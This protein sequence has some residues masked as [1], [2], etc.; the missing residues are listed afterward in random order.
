MKTVRSM[1]PPGFLMMTGTGTVWHLTRLQRV[2][3]RWICIQWWRLWWYRKR[4]Q[5]S[6]IGILRRCRSIVM[7]QLRRCEW[8]DNLESRLWWWW[9][10]FKRDN[11]QPVY[12]ATYYVEDDSDCDDMEANSYPGNTKIAMISTMTV[13]DIRTM[14]IV[15]ISR[16][17]NFL[18]RWWWEGRTRRCRCRHVLP[19]GYSE[20]GDDC[21]DS[22]ERQPAC[23][24][25]LVWR[26]RPRLWWWV[27]LWSRW[28][29][30][31]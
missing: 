21:N 8:C 19:S 24:W 27:R 2:L 10:W 14:T 3:F 22:N 11:A 25:G 17:P 29:W 26:N 7:V 12:A 18:C 4:H 13:M 15:S 5:S 16:R 30:I 6:G 23:W 20:N 1:L 28:R 31:R 9:I